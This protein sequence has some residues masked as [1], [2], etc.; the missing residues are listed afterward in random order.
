ML[1]NQKQAQ[2]FK[3]YV[4]CKTENSRETAYRIVG[5]L[6]EL[7]ESD[8]K[9]EYLNKYILPVLLNIQPEVRLSS[10]KS[11][12]VGLKNFGSTCYMN[13]MLQVLNNVGP[14]RNSL[15]NVNSELNLIKELKKLFAG[16]YFS[17]RLDYAPGDLLAAF[18]PP[19][20]PGLQQDT[21]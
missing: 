7:S 4:I 6:H 16:L 18:V 13:S 11:M 10:S 2:H 17:E 9:E 12:A 20:N 21:T 8:D 15:M 19:I 3:N 5:R 14:F 1:T